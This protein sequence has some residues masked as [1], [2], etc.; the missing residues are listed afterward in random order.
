MRTKVRLKGGRRFMAATRR[1]LADKPASDE[2]LRRLQNL[3]YEFHA[4][5]R[6]DEAK[7]HLLWLMEI[8]ESEKTINPRA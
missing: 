1:E 8:A 3:I 5:G 2:L 6:F 4:L 7:P